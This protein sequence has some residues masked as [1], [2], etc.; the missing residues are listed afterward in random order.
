[1]N[2]NI[3]TGDL[4]RFR[5]SDISE[6]AVGIVLYRISDVEDLTSSL[7]KWFWE[8]GF[9]Q[10]TMSIDDYITSTNL[11]VLVVLGPDGLD[12]I[13]EG[14]CTTLTLAGSNL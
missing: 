11:P 1:M 2:R 7:R 9:G 6:Q 3:N 8:L 13:D 10:A 12:W 4:I 14:Y 5:H